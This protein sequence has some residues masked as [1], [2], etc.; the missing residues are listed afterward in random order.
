MAVSTYTYDAL[1]PEEQVAL[2]GPA[3]LAVQTSSTDG[4]TA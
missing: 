4:F 2:P 1:P 3:D